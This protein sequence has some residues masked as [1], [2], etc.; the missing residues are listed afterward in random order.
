V[1]KLDGGAAAWRAAVDEMRADPTAVAS[2]DPADAVDLG[3]FRDA[4]TKA[5]QQQQ[6]QEQGCGPP[7]APCAAVVID[8]R[9]TDEREHFGSIAGA[10]HLAVEDLPARIAAA[11]AAQRLPWTSTACGPGVS[12]DSV[13]AAAPG[14]RRVLVHCR[15]NRRARFFAWLLK[16]IGVDAKFYTGGV[17]EWSTVDETVKAYPSF[18]VGE[19]VPASLAP[20]K[21]KL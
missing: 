11:S 9:R 3:T 17:C 16:D 15:T 6:Q 1:F 10:V 18:E 2:Y 8:A 12:G 14:T 13:C 20:G 7:D 19:P 4:V 21:T 5:Q